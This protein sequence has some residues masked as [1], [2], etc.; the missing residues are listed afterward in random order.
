[1]TIAR[2]LLGVSL[3]LAVTACN[4]IPIDGLQRNF[5]VKVTQVENNTEPVKVDF[6]WVIDNSASMCQE[7]ASLAGSFDEFLQRISSFVNIDFRIA[8]VTTDMLSEEHSGRFRHHKTTEFPFACAETSIR[9]CLR[10]EDDMCTQGYDEPG[11]PAREGLGSNWVCDAPDK[12]KNITNCNES[13]NSKCRKLC[14]S[15]AECDA[16]FFGAEQGTSCK[17]DPGTCRYKCLIPSGDPN[18]SGCVLRPQ[19]TV[20]P[21]TE[22]MYSLLVQ[23]AGKDPNQGICESNGVPC[24]V[25]DG[26]P[27]GS[28]CARPAAYLTPST[29]DEL[30]KCVGVVGAEQHN[31]ANLEQGLNAAIF[32]LDK[33][34]PNALQAR[35]F[36]RDDAYLVIV[37]VSDEDDCS[38]DDNRELK[39]EQYGT[40]TCLPDTNN[41]GK[42]RPVNEAVNRIKALKQDPGFVLV[43]AIV[44]DSQLEEEGA[45]TENREDYFASKCSKCEEP[46]AQHP[47]LFNTYICES[48][49]G[50]AD[51]GS[52]YVKF[53]NKFGKNGILTNICSDAGVA[54]ALDTIADRIIRVF[55]KICLPRAVDEDQDLV[56]HK[57]G[58]QGNC[59]S[60]AACCIKTSQQ[61]PDPEECEDGTLCEPV[62]SE[63]LTESD[64]PDTF[65]YK[66]QASSDC[67]ETP[68]KRAVFFN[69]LLEPGSGVEI[70]YQ[71]A[72]KVDPTVAPE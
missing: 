1:M 42:M 26:C 39:K 61:C 40:C 55:T 51:F 2:A 7:Q 60:G 24:Y 34:G 6:L 25:S 12:V 54:P 23:G 14:E 64:E 16:Q 5:F 70:D 71:A 21:G 22:D 35:E 41:G 66:V 62:R 58:P 67:T 43:A 33:N 37:F 49:A 52:R 50:K 38:V 17:D 13:L 69:F 65:T 72:T 18:N 10:G 9:Y 63:Q 36:L 20:C 48:A 3:L 27:D 15:D 57:L 4:N 45:I 53:V 56:I 32:A 31:N 68:D 59:A 29:A 46:G 28:K 19:T 30:F 11:L 44:G 47:L 8:V